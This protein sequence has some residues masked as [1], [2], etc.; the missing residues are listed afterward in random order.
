MEIND[1]TLRAWVEEVKKKYEGGRDFLGAV[2]DVVLLHGHRMS[3]AD[4][5]RLRETLIDTLNKEKLPSVERTE[6]RSALVYAG[7]MSGS[8]VERTAGIDRSLPNGDR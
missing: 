2:R 1:E 7:R 5:N 8:R 3:F 4:Q 6:P